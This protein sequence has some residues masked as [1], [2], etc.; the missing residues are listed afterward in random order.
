M[1]GPPAMNGVLPKEWRK[2][3]ERSNT[4]KLAEIRHKTEGRNTREAPEN[5]FWRTLVAD[6]SS[7]GSACPPWYQLASEH[8][9]Q[10]SNGLDL[11]TRRLMFESSPGIV[12]DFLNR[13]QSVIW[14]RRLATLD[15]RYVVLGPRSCELG[16]LVCILYGCSVP[17]ILRQ[18]GDGEQ[19][20][21]MGECYVHGMMDG[22]AIMLKDQQDMPIKH[23]RLV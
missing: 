14:G 4:H 6:R 11:D 9:L 21:F 5:W 1:I 13:V 10:N 3:V 22:E 16:D 19:Y 12:L 2:I 17:V 15:Q 18:I 8:V 20:I 23:F 7:T